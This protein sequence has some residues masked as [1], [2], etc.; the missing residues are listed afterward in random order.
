MAT[1]HFSRLVYS[2]FNFDSDTTTSLSFLDHLFNKNQV[3]PGKNSIVRETYIMILMIDLKRCSRYIVRQSGYGTQQITRSL[4]FPKIDNI[5]LT[6]CRVNLHHRQWCTNT[7]GTIENIDA[8]NDRISLTEGRNDLQSAR[9][10]CLRG[11]I[12][13]FSLGDFLIVR[14]EGVKQVIDDVRCTKFC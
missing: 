8:N 12:P 9:P 11:S 10:D 14:C 6:I 7:Q 3:R 4:H 5:L 13:T 1:K 2:V